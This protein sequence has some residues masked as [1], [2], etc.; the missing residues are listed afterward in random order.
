VNPTVTGGGVRRS[1][2]RL[3]AD[4]SRVVTMLFVPGRAGSDRQELRTSAVVS[5]ILALD[6]DEVERSLDDVA[7]RF[8]HRH[9][10]LKGP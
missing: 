5:R 9:R 2:Q 8:E 3:A 4:R 6:D 7:A 10:D 1:A